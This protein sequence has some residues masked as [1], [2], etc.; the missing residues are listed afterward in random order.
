[1]PHVTALRHRGS[2]FRVGTFDLSQVSALLKIILIDIVMSSDNAIVIGILAATVLRICFAMVTFELL[3]IIGLLL[4]G[5]LLLLW[6]CWKMWREIRAAGARKLAEGLDDN[7]G[8]DNDKPVTS[9]RQALMCPCRSTTCSL[10]QAP[11]MAIRAC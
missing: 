4:A 7:L 8:L 1:V 9:L 11:H 2:R 10:S 6:V 5:G 3:S